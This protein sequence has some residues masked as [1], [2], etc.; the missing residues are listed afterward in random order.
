MA[1]T[2]TIPARA[3]INRAEEIIHARIKS[4]SIFL[5]GN[6]V[7]FEVSRVNKTTFTLTSHTFSVI[8]ADFLAIAASVPTGSNLYAYIKNGLWDYINSKK[9]IN[10][11]LY[12]NDL[13]P[14]DASDTD[15][16]LFESQTLWTQE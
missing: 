10:D 13:V 1:Y 4:I 11:E 6:S 3:D 2:F 14:L 16:T 7:N 12:F 15:G 8:G 9:I 5:E